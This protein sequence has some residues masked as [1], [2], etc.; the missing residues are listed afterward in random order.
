[1]NDVRPETDLDSVPGARPMEPSILRHNNIS[2]SVTFK[3]KYVERRFHHLHM[4]EVHLGKTTDPLKG[5]KNT[6]QIPRSK[7]RKKHAT[8][9]AY[10]RR[11]PIEYK[12]RK[13]QREPTAKQMDKHE[14]K[15]AKR[16][17]E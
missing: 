4:T 5:R 1:M 6:I 14:R 16:F 11:D 10:R 8:I 9:R 17:R 12:E 13:D 7:I 3:Q 2:K 15:E